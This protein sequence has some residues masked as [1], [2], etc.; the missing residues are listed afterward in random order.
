MR[1]RNRIEAL[2]QRHARRASLR[3]PGSRLSTTL[4]DADTMPP[5]LRRAHRNLDRAVDRL[6]RPTPFASERERV[7]HL[8]A[9]Y[10]KMRAPLEA[11][12]RRKKLGRR[13]KR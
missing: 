12:M 13:R 8:F 6:Y 7:E 10:E 4:Y 5:A 11:G 9:L 3:F 1:R 2:S